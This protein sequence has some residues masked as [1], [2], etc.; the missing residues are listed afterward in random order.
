[1]SRS[2]INSIGLVAIGSPTLIQALD[3]YFSFQ[4]LTFHLKSAAGSL[5]N[6]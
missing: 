6:N 2:Q 1:M 5:I 4:K 3:V